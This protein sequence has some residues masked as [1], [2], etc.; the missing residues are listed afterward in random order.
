MTAARRALLDAAGRRIAAARPELARRHD[1]TTMEGLLAARAGIAS[2]EDTEAVLATVVVHHLDLPEWIRS[3][4]AYAFA[5]E[6]G[7]A[8]AWRA[9]FTRTVFLAGTPDHLRARFSFAHIAADGSAA[10]TAP[11]PAG[12]PSSLRRLLKL[13]DGAAPVTGGADT[14][15]RLPRAPGGPDRP[16]TDRELYLA[17]AG[18][19]V[20]DALVDLHHVLAESVLDGMIRPGDRL[21]LRQ[22]P[23]L[24]GEVPRLAA[25][26]VVPETSGRLRAT[27]GLSKEALL[28]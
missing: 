7:A 8:A 15:V 4:C 22:V 6:A 16:G 20:S 3:A 28:V 23:R 24:T 9:S 26:R 14:A 27:A 11:A 2:E 10:W 1:L 18:R 19:T 5:L 17:V 12:A 13:F 25:L 21:M